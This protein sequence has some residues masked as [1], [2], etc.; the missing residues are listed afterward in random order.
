M[1]FGRKDGANLMLALTCD[2]SRASVLARAGYRSVENFLL[3]IGL[4]HLG[5]FSERL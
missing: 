3:L 5:A 1:V 4:V 2:V